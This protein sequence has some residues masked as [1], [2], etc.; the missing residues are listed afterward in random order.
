ML[1]EGF[2][3]VI[4]TDN[5]LVS[6]TNM[7]KEFEKAVSYCGMTKEE[8]VSV[9]KESFDKCYFSKSYS[10]KLLYLKKVY[11]AIDR[12]ASKYIQNIKK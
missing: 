12:V 9:C 5:M 2:S 3:I 8:I 4:A 7:V 10:E 6:S 1:N 11:D